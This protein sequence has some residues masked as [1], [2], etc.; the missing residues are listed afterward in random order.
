MTPKQRLL[1]AAAAQINMSK[2]NI[3][4]KCFVDRLTAREQ[5]DFICQELLQRRLGSF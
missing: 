2:L 1:Q 4:A 3:Q 5:R